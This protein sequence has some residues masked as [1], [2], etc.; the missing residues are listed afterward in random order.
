MK[1]SVVASDGTDVAVSARQLRKV[2]GSTVALESISV[3]LGRGEFLAVIG[4]SGCGKS[5]LL[6]CLAGLM[7]YDGE[8]LAGGRPVDGPGI[9]RGVVFQNYALFPWLRVRDNVAFGLRGRLGRRD[10]ETR[11]SNVLELVG[12][13]E[14]AQNWP[15]E[16]SGG[17]AQ[18]V[19]IA[20]ALAPQPAVLLM[21]EPFG[22]L[23]ALTRSELQDE[24][25]RVANSTNA[26]VLFVTHSVVEA[27]RMADRVLVL[28]HGRVADDLRLKGPRPRSMDDEESL[29]AAHRLEVA[30]GLHSLT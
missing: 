23:D 26:T 7:P 4:R 29:S 16:L 27:V 28:E 11:V 18:R 5:T 19:A 3:E 1:L 2:Y 14:W 22:A 20:R 21:D 15:S 24:V 8:L 30:L 25:V 10:A 13:K 6:R 17:M 9:D 12:L